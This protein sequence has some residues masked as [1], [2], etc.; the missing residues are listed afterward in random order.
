MHDEIDFEILGDDNTG[1]IQLQ[2]NYFV[3]GK[4][5]HE[6]RLR[7]WF[8]PTLDFHEYKFQVSKDAVRSATLKPWS[9]QGRHV[10]ALESS[11]WLVQALSPLPVPRLQELL[12]GV[13]A[14]QRRQ[15]SKARAVIAEA[16]C[17][18]PTAKGFCKGP[19]GVDVHRVLFRS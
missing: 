7:F 6:E 10:H 9:P 14:R 11:S 5:G 18:V 8:D 2:T 17:T 4:G 3:G 16:K 19:F 12:P 15:G 13:C 1:E